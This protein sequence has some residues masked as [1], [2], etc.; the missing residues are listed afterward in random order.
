VL[1]TLTNSA[2]ATADY[3]CD[4]LSGKGASSL[5]INTDTASNAIRVKF[6]RN[7]E[8]IHA[9]T[10]ISPGDVSAVWLRRPEPIV[11]GRGISPEQEHCSQEWA[12]ALEGFL[13]QIP[14]RRWVN[15]PTANALASHKIDQLARAQRLGLMVPKTIVTQDVDELREF[16]QQCGGRIISKPLSSGYIERIAPGKDSLIYTNRV[17]QKQLARRSLLGKCPTLFQEE[18]GKKTDVRVCFVDGD[19][20]A[21]SL[22]AIGDDGCQRLD[23]RRNN[24]LDVRYKKIELPAKIKQLTVKLVEFYRLRFAAVDFVIDTSGD[25]F[26]LEINPNGQWAWL[27]LDAGMSIADAL[28]SAFGYG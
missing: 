1:I 11:C 22:G 2:D 4:L 15:H 10:A 6:A 9:G 13:A 8:I 16:Y 26:F 28:I 18:I 27:D 17:L 21:V 5:R 3:L 19:A 23:V 20:Y 12:E 7:V 14:F 25:W 24:M